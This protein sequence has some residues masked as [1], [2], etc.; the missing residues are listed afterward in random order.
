MNH[1]LLSRLR[2]KINNPY[3]KRRVKSCM[4]SQKYREIKH[5]EL[6]HFELIERN[7]N[8][9]NNKH[10]VRNYLYKGRKTKS[11]FT[12]TSNIYNSKNR[13]RMSYR[14]EDLMCNKPNISNMI[15]E[16]KSEINKK[17]NIISLDS[18]KKLTSKK[19]VNRLRSKSVY[20]ST[21]KSN[22][23][24]PRC[25]SWHSGLTKYIPESSVRP[26]GVIYHK[27]ININDFI[28]ENLETKIKNLKI[29][30]DF[31]KK[32]LTNVSMDLVKSELEKIQLNN[33][34]K[35]KLIKLKKQKWRAWNAYMNIK[36]PEF[37]N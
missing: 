18:N 6:K 8:I 15:E 34:N 21:D 33:N 24:R 31:N 16:Y 26:S 36:F 7:F 27:P 30:L 5:R 35:Q 25:S 20:F 2:N 19:S 3:I 11:Y 37:Y 32:V 1:R 23:L 29:E 12:K 13:S 14:R 10:K 17:G 9:L 28:I 22:N 4:K